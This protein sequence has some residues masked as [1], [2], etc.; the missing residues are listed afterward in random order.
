MR[1]SFRNRNASGSGVNKKATLHQDGLYAR[2]FFPSLE[3]PI[4]WEQ[5]A[6]IRPPW[7]S[8]LGWQAPHTAGPFL[9]SREPYTEPAWLSIE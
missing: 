5:L 4:R 8:D 1:C 7:D 2:T 3:G 9:M 6:P